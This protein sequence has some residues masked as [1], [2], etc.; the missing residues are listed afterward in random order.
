M[1]ESAINYSFLNKLS[2]LTQYNDPIDRSLYE[3]YDVKRGLRYSDGRGV[4]VGL[5]NIGDVLGYELDKDGHAV[6]IP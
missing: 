5:T 6:A 2:L 3:K 4:L 1:T